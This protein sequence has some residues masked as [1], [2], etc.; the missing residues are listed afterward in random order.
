MEQQTIGFIGCGNMA[1]A[2]IRG[3]VF[4]HAAA[5]ES[6]IVSD[7]DSVKV[8]GF[9]KSVGIR[10]AGGNSDVAK[11][12]DILFLAVKPQVY[13][14]VIEEI[15][16]DVMPGAVIVTIAAG[17]SIDVTE[18]R[19]GRPIKLIRAMP[20]T[21]AMVGEGMSALSPNA[22]V[23][24]AETDA[25]K[26]L[27]A[28][29]GEAEIV[30]EHLM[31]AVVAVSGSSPAFVFMF[32]EALAD[33][34]VDAGM[35]RAQAY[36]FAAQSVLGSAKMVLDLDKHPAELKDMVCSPAGTTIAA[37]A[38]LEKD[39]FRHAVIDAVD[40]CVARSKAL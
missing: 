12:S 36:H 30:P 23:S 13:P 17:Q 8:H 16:N 14:A 20:N 22:N 33:G 32:I 5:P 11:G 21:P 35:P 6:I 2:M 3:M 38:A 29:F 34:A 15:R 18:Q 40:Q 26:A 10:A 24:A 31:D 27:F 37:V 39:G 19:F 7:A 1:Q 28:S 9:A 25:V 4:H